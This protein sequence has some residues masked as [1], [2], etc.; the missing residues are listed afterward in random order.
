M[1]QA[2]FSKSLMLERL[3]KQIEQMEK[4]YGFNNNNGYSQVEHKS[5]E[6]NRLYGEYTCLVGLKDEIESNYFYYVE[7]QEA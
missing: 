5:K 4:D 7:K 3:E 1:A 6:L 2:K